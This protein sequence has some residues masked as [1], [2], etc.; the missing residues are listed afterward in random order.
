[1]NHIDKYKY[2]PFHFR[3]K[4]YL[5]NNLKDVSYFGFQNDWLILQ[6]GKGNENWSAG[7]D[8]SIGLSKES[9]AYS[10]MLLGSDYGNIKVRY[11]H[12]FLEKLEPN[13]NRY[14]NARAVEWTNK[15]SMSFGLSETIIYS[16]DNRSLDFGYFNPISSHLEIELNNRLNF[17]GDAHANAVWQ[18]HFKSIIKDR[19][20]FYLN[21]LFDELVLDPNIQIGKEHGKAFSLKI[22]YKKIFNN[23][24]QSK[25]YSSLISVGTP[26]FRHKNGKNNFIKNNLPLGWQNG[27]DGRFLIAGLDLFYKQEFKVLLSCSYFESGSQSILNDGYASYGNYKKGPFPS[28]EIY[29][30]IITDLIFEKYIKKKILFNIGFS[31]H[32]DGRAKNFETY[33]GIGFQDSLK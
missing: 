4:S 22:E 18:F 8:I 5:H 31:N 11:I 15:N 10:Y 19:F 3:S 23:Q 21:Y 2:I 13:V 9:D 29:D 7:E 32:N 26:T 25:F 28:G 24:I 33:I 12:G 30:S 14:V 17:Y 1:M 16:G 6:I 20:I 27:S